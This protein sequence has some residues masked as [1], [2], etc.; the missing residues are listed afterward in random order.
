MAGQ[1]QGP[2]FGT[3]HNKA[4][5]RQ[6]RCFTAVHGAHGQAHVVRNVDAEQAHAAVNKHELGAARMQAAKGG[7]AFAQVLL[8]GQHGFATVVE[9][10]SD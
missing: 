5:L 4:G 2:P 9:R 8:A 1:S 6:V 7:Q 10:N 3:A